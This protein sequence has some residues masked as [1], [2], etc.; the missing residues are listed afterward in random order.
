MTG[1]LAPLLLPALAAAILPGL[2]GWAFTRRFGPL[3]L[4]L[5][6]G[7]CAVIALAGWFP[8]RQ[9]LPGDIM[10]IAGPLIFMVL[11]PALVSLVTGAAIGFWQA[12]RRR[13]G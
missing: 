9:T 8:T 13:L 5:A 2:I 10:A 11:L 6:L 12:H 1:T 7:V 3:G 4:G